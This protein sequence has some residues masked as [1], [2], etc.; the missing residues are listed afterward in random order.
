MSLFRLKL[1]KRLLI[2]FSL[3]VLVMQLLPQGTFAYQRSNGANDV[4]GLTPQEQEYI[5]QNSVLRAAVLRGVAP[6]MYVDQTG[7]VK[8]I[9][10]MVLDEITATTGLQFDLQVFD[11]IQQIVEKG[12]D[13][14]VFL[15]VA[16]AYTADVP[17][18]ELSTPFLCSNTILYLHKSVDPADL[19]DKTIAMVRG[20]TVPAGIPRAKIAYFDTREAALTAVNNGHADYGYGNFYS[21]SYYTL[22]N[23]YRNLIT[24][25]VKQDKR[26]YCLGLLHQDDLL[27]SIVNKA[28]TAIDVDKMQAIILT[29]TTSVNQELTFDMFLEVYGAYVLL[30]MLVIIILLICWLN[31]HL[32]SRAILQ[33]QNQ[34]YMILAALSNEFLFEYDPA[35]DNFTLFQHGLDFF[36]EDCIE[37]ISDAVK[38]TLVPTLP[39]PKPGSA[40]KNISTV[41]CEKGTFRLITDNVY[42]NDGQVQAVIGKLVDVSQEMA[43]K[44]ALITRARLDGLT[45]LYNATTIRELV[46]ARLEQKNPN[47]LDAFLLLDADSFKEINDK[48][49]HYTGDQ[50]LKNL[51]KT[52][53]HIFRATDIIGRHGGDEFCIYMEKVPSREF[54]ENKCHQLIN[55]VRCT[56]EGIALSVCVGATLVTDKLSYEEIFRTAD[57]ALYLA[58]GR[59]TAQAVVVDQPRGQ[60]PQPRGRSPWL[61][62]R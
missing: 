31:S 19:A 15:G 45:G 6:I 53:S 35:T 38:K 1:T 36:D 37:V 21:I 29:A 18:M 62:P 51:A 13:L 22:Q 28:I 5:A 59:G 9:G 12:Q 52:L 49:G 11:S 40:C 25:P 2:I 55:S 20:G 48:L 26:E 47:T 54:V 16:A 17:D 56:V 43:E 10:K 24:I 60:S 46:E 34:R 50:V 3:A 61:V 4:L 14:D 32:R 44:E 41:V 39:H 7:E 27:L 30:A 42:T 23:R 8:G 58:K 57:D 33:V